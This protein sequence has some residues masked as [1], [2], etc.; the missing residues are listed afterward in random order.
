MIVIQKKSSLK[1]HNYV[2][3]NVIQVREQPEA[4]Q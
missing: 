4:A 2:G 1:Q 3:M